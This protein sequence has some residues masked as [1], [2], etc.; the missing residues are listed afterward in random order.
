MGNLFTDCWFVAGAESSPPSSV[1]LL[2]FE[3]CVTLIDLLTDLF[4]VTG[5]FGLVVQITFSFS[6]GGITV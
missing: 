5:E 4:G 3:H 6:L 1:L 2:L